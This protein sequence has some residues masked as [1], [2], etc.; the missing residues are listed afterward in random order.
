MRLRPLY[1]FAFSTTR[2]V[3]GSMPPAPAAAARGAAA[4]PA[5]T[6]PAASATTAAAA[7]RAGG[8]GAVEWN[9]LTSE[10]SSHVFVNEGGE[11]VTLSWGDALRDTTHGSLQPRRRMVVGTYSFHTWRVRS[12]ARGLIAEYTGTYSFHTWRVR[13]PARGLIAEYTGPSAVIT[14]TPD[15][16]TAR[17]NANCHGPTANGLLTNG[18][19]AAAVSASAAALPLPPAAAAA[20]AAGCLPSG[21]P[22]GYRQR[23]TVLG[24]PIWAFDVVSDAAVSRLA[25]VVGRMLSG[26]PAELL[27]R[28]REGGA[29]FAVFG[30]EQVVSDVPAHS[31][32]RHN[33]DRDLDASSRGLGATPCLPVTS[34]GEENLTMEGDRWYPCQSILVHEVGHAV[35]NMGMRPGGRRGQAAAGAAGG[36]LASGGGGGGPTGPPGVEEVLEAYLAAMQDRLYPAG[37]YMATNEQ[38]YWAVAVESW[39]ESTVRDDVNGGIRTRAALRS[40]D[41]RLA[42]LLEATFGDGP[43][44]YWHD[45]PR[46]LAM[47]SRPPAAAAAAGPTHGSGGGGRSASGGGGIA[48]A[49]AAVPLPVPPLARQRSSR[50]GFVAVGGGGG[51]SV[52]TTPQAGSGGGGAA[53]GGGTPGGGGGGSTPGGGGTPG[54]ASWRSRRPAQLSIVEVESGAGSA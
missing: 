44:R 7:S 36:G 17:Q 42:A 43:W 23:S 26:C 52:P 11:A 14:I 48:A 22:P 3:T 49:A 19:G 32:M 30:R 13:S 41:P 20:A 18:G 24:M 53:A 21:L 54:S 16:Y 12:P 47:P 34:C 46:P 5:A 4:T 28:L 33:T 6:T 9:G 29:S 39:F 37:C 40:H 31:F 50:S 27:G 51:G 25:A 8:G 45:C 10:A 15:G 2:F 35:L 38:E 1:L